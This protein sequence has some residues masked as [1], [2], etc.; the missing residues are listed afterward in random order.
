MGRRRT[1]PCMQIHVSIVD[2]EAAA[3]S[4][5]GLE[6]EAGGERVSVVI[7]L[8]TRDCTRTPPIDPEALVR[9]IV[10]ICAS[11]SANPTPQ[12]LDRLAVKNGARILFV[13]ARDVDWIEAEGNYV[14]VHVGKTTYTLRESIGSLE[15]QLDPTLFKRIHRSTIVNVERIRELW[16]QAHGDYRVTLDTGA[17]LTLSR[18]YRETLNRLLENSL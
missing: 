15:Q 18:S 4:S 14:L 12:Y 3:R 11:A 16:A 9:N 13:R 6:V 2:D 17:Q 5:D 1:V 8:D 7:S 10:R